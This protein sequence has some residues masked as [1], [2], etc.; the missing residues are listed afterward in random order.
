[1]DIH[2]G[3][4]SAVFKRIYDVNKNNRLTREKERKG[5]REERDRRVCPV[6]D[7]RSNGHPVSIAHQM[8]SRTSALRED[9]LPRS[10]GSDRYGCRSAPNPFFA[11]CSDYVDTAA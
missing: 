8:T 9:R 7:D 1:M 2:Q 6:L 4:R 10:D 11:A 5:E 3:T